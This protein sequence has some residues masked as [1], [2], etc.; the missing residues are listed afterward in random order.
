M[1]RICPDDELRKNLYME[2]FTETLEEIE[3]QYPPVIDRLGVETL[4]SQFGES[5]PRCL[6]TN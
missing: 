5:D 4:F 1:I 3:Q 2:E 6:R